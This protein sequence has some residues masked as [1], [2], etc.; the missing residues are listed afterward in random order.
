MSLRDSSWLLGSISDPITVHPSTTSL[1]TE[2]SQRATLRHV[3]VGGAWFS[4]RKRTLTTYWTFSAMQL[5]YSDLLPAESLYFSMLG[6]GQLHLISSR[7]RLIP[8]KGHRSLPSASSIS[9]RPE[10]SHEQTD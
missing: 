4:D 6:H 3:S 8:E 2:I 10:S 7:A 5:G 9:L 1:I